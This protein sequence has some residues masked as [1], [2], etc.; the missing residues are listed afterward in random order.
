[1]VGHWRTS[2]REKVIPAP[3]GHCLPTGGRVDAGQIVCAKRKPSH[4]SIEESAC[5]P[6]PLMGGRPKGIRRPR[7][8]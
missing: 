6:P 4:H 3:I 1:M 2:A 5:P 7:P 8:R